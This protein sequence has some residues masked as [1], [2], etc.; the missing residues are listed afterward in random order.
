MMR[1]AFISARERLNEKED[2]HKKEPAPQSSTV[3]EKLHN[4]LRWSR[5]S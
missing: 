3:L 2:L 5:K 1:K 4:L